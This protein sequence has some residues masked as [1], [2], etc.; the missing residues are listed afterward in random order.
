MYPSNDWHAIYRLQGVVN[1]LSSYLKHGGIFL[2]RDYGRYDFSQLRFKKGKASV[3]SSYIHVCKHTIN[4]TPFLDYMY[5]ILSSLFFFYKQASVYQRISTHVETEPV[6]TFL[7]KVNWNNCLIGGEKIRTILMRKSEDMLQNILD[8]FVE[9]LEK[10][11]VT[12]VKML[13]VVACR[14]SW[15]K[16]SNVN[17]PLTKGTQVNSNFWPQ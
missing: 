9:I 14:S 8:S 3:W 15:L 10:D 7:L 5:K 17:T 1:R 12:W 6:C 11:W 2:F 4:Y 13:H 16:F